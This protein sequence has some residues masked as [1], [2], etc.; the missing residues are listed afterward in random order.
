MIIWLWIWENDV[1]FFFFLTM[2]FIV[3]VWMVEDLGMDLAIYCYLGRLNIQEN[4]LWLAGWT[5]G[6]Q[7]FDSN[8]QMMKWFYGFM[9][10]M[11][12]F[13]RQL[14]FSTGP[15]TFFGFVPFVAFNRNHKLLKSKKNQKSIENRS[16][17]SKLIWKRLLQV[18]QTKVLLV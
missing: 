8:S 1:F 14:L 16:N 4:Q 15:K 12:F 9:V 5:E 7:S 11:S 3:A 17:R 18:F 13:E 10:S 6:C 2:G